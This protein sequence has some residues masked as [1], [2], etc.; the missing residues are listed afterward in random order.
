MRRA[1]SCMNNMPNWAAWGSL[2]EEQL[3]GG[4]ED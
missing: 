2:A 4:V 1:E 3:A